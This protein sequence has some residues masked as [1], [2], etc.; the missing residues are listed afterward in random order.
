MI[1]GPADVREDDRLRA[2]LVDTGLDPEDPPGIEVDDVREGLDGQLIHGSQARDGTLRVEPV[3]PNL[4]GTLEQAR[5]L[6]GHVE[7]EERD[8]PVA[9]YEGEGMV[10]AL[11][12]VRG[13]EPQ[14]DE[15]PL[16]RKSVV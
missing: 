2:L 8:L 12:D 15:V 14:V 16:D 5:S 4:E 1:E 3:R 13:V 9:V 10:D 11:L 6:H 7:D